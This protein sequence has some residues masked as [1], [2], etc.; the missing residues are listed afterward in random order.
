M[1]T[2]KYVLLLYTEKCQ[3]HDIINHMVEL[4]CLLKPRGSYSYTWKT[5]FSGLG[6]NTLGEE[7]MEFRQERSWEENKTTADREISL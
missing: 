4:Y 7:S 2:E 3:E 5:S 1:L 6:K